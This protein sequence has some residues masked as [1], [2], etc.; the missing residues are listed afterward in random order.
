MHIWAGSGS[1]S[2]KETVR[3]KPMTPKRIGRGLRKRYSSARVGM[4]MDD[5]CSV[6]NFGS[7]SQSM[8]P[9]ECDSGIECDIESESSDTTISSYDVEEDMVNPLD[10]GALDNGLSSAEIFPTPK[11]HKGKDS[12]D[13]TIVDSEDDGMKSRGTKVLERIKAN[14]QRLDE[15]KKKFEILKYDTLIRKRL[16]TPRD[17]NQFGASGTVDPLDSRTPLSVTDN[18]NV[19]V[20]GNMD[21][22]GLQN[23]RQKRPQPSD[24]SSDGG[25]LLTKNLDHTN[26]MTP[27]HL[28][29][30]KTAGLTQKDRQHFTYNEFDNVLEDVLIAEEV[31][32]SESLNGNAD[33]VAAAVYRSTM[34]SEEQS[35]FEESLD[36]SQQQLS[37][38]DALDEHPDDDIWHEKYGNKHP[39]LPEVDILDTNI[40]NSSIEVPSL[41]SEVGESRNTSSLQSCENGTPLEEKK[42]CASGLKRNIWNKDWGPSYLVIPDV[43]LGSRT[44]SKNQSTSVS[45]EGVSDNLS[46]SSS[47]ATRAQS[48]S[49]E[50]KV[51]ETPSWSSLSANTSAEAEVEDGKFQFVAHFLTP[52]SRTQSPLL[53]H[54][55]SGIGS[56]ALSSFEKLANPSEYEEDNTEDFESFS[57]VHRMGGPNGTPLSI[58]LKYGFDIKARVDSGEIEDVRNILS[59]G[60]CSPVY[61]IADYLGSK[62]YSSD[63]YQRDYGI[64]PAYDREHGF[65]LKGK[66]NL[67]D[68]EDERNIEDSER[69]SP[70]NERI[71]SALTPKQ[72]ISMYRKDEDYEISR[73][74]NASISSSFKSPDVEGPIKSI[75]NG[76]KTCLPNS[77]PA[78]D[79]K[80]QI[81]ERK[82]GFHLDTKF[83]TVRRSMM[84]LDGPNS[85]PLLAVDPGPVERTWS[86]SPRK[87][88]QKVNRSK[89]P[90]NMLKSSNSSLG[91]IFQNSRVEGMEGEIRDLRADVG[92]LKGLVDGLEKRL[93]GMED[94]QERGAQRS[95]Q[96]EDKTNEIWRALFGKEW[97][98]EKFCEEGEYWK[99]FEE[100]ECMRSVR[101]AGLLRVLGGMK[102]EMDEE[103]KEMGRDERFWK[104]GVIEKSVKDSNISAESTPQKRDK[105]KGI[106]DVRTDTHNSFQYQRSEQLALAEVE[107]NNDLMSRIW[108]LENHVN[109]ILERE[110]ESASL[111]VQ[112]LTASLSLNKIRSFS[113]LPELDKGGRYSPGLK[114]RLC[115]SLMEN[116]D[117]EEIES[118]MRNDTSGKGKALLG[119]L[120]E[121]GEK[122]EGREQHDSDSL[123]S[124]AEVFDK[125]H[126]PDVNVESVFEDEKVAYQDVSSK[127]S[128]NQFQEREASPGIQEM[129]SQRLDKGKRKEIKGSFVSLKKRKKSR[130]QIGSWRPNAEEL[131]E[132][133]ENEGSSAEKVLGL[134]SKKSKG[135]G[136]EKGKGKEMKEVLEDEGSSAR[137]QEE[138][139]FTINLGDVKEQ[140]REQKEE[141]DTEEK[142]ISSQDEFARKEEQVQNLE[143]WMRNLAIRSLAEKKK[144]DTEEKTTCSKDELVREQEKVQNLEYW[145]RYLAMS[146]LEEKKMIQGE[147]E[148]ERGRHKEESARLR[149]LVE[150]LRGLIWGCGG[151]EGTGD[152]EGAGDEEG[153]G[154]KGKNKGEGDGDEGMGKV[155][156]VNFGECQCGGLYGG[157]KPSNVANMRERD[158]CRGEGGME[159]ERKDG[160]SEDNGISENDDDGESGYGY[161]FGIGI[162]SANASANGNG[163]GKGFWDWLGGSILWRQD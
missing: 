125:G 48:D 71:I 89:S 122:E 20:S 93:K 107:K 25:V 134:D 97:N 31:I 33:V 1:S 3:R 26:R 50:A 108:T 28:P 40:R 56:E 73:S 39:Y 24:E 129:K 102:Q 72:T 5:S 161:D 21:L 158:V 57:P 149:G 49:S 47:S 121:M 60:S 143:Y 118:M 42:P 38:L 119:K 101:D 111:E 124:L 154:G 36:I 46:A 68:A 4:G 82:L 85:P 94:N 83:N 113:D 99:D 78:A 114:I 10:V 8:T 2:G 41:V 11:A 44:R 30:L 86:P 127:D 59:S 66:N 65:N 128:L 76:G 43:I 152:E 95:A 6:D 70:V 100:V 58:G 155:K 137:L 69:F 37:E 80:V 29:R 55:L 77:E 90:S 51:D 63:L 15:D 53:E 138:G 22:Q 109:G 19:V 74:H 9:A 126:N 98:G 92:D 104:E 88:L 147:W 115:K 67:A 14:V 146:S 87:K 150:D 12:K 132:L 162:G 106:K 45:L 7:L 141:M 23:Q 16:P 160:S 112:E 140:G 135:K 35:V 32:H 120:D 27:K 110:G 84:Q 148:T 144:I 157:G 142:P 136:R 81:N 139:F 75:L 133:I 61:P 62:V 18:H 17:D 116:F 130:G 153:K 91:R 64:P 117:R 159:E 79:A 145:I 163:N 52:S 156:G 131:E 105:G 151:E 54:D 13:M 96:V 123:E 34:N 103:K